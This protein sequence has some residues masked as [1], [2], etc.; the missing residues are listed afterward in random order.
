MKVAIIIPGQPRNIQVAY[1]SLK[2]HY[3]NKHDCDIFIHTWFDTKFPL[4]VYNEMLTLF[5]PKKILI[6]EQVIFDKE[7]RK[8]EPWNT[9]LQNLLSMYYSMYT[10]NQL[11]M[12]YEEEKGFKYDFVIKMRS[13][14]QIH[15]PIP[16]EDIQT[17]KLALYRWTQ[18]N[19]TGSSDVF[20]IGS[21]QIMD[22]Y[23]DLYNK[24]MYY[25]DSDVTWNISEAKMRAEYILHHH[26][27]TNKIPVQI[28]WHG[29]QTDPS[30]HLIR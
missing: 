8:Q 6:E 3:L 7:G 1:E 14:L 23:S 15:R 13:D 20:A 18:L 30:F 9:P 11:K 26:I 10:G 5:K 21:S 24:V 4:S 22:I 28:F 29:D 19:Y 17:D 16:L 25:L 2:E 12:M 27:N